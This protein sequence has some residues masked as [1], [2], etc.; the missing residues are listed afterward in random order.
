MFR[1]LVT[2]L[3]CYFLV[4]PVYPRRTVAAGGTTI[5]D[6]FGDASITGWSTHIDTGETHCTWTE[7]TGDI[8]LDMTGTGC[9]FENTAARFDTTLGSADAWCKIQI[10]NRGAEA[11]EGNPGFLLRGESGADFG[12]RMHLRPKTDTWSSNTGVILEKHS[13][14]DESYDADVADEQTCGSWSDLDYITMKLTGTGSSLEVKVWDNDG[15]DPGDC[16]EGD[17][18]CGWG[19]P[20]CTIDSGTSGFTVGN[21]DDTGNFFGLAG[22][23]ENSSTDDD[24]GW[25]DWKCGDL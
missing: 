16:D 20:T 3:A 17:A 19:T 18:N 10:Q 12:D 15:S 14:G 13:N 5:S 11:G 22:Y 7:D 23:T 25:A 24:H 21:V 2:L 6:D 8:Y 4:A 9:K 1:A